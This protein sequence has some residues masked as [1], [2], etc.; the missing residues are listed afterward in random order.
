MTHLRHQRPGFAL[1]HKC[2][3]H[4]R[5]LEHDPEKWSVCG[6]DRAPPIELITLQGLRC[7]L[8]RTM[9]RRDLITTFVA[10]AA[11][12]VTTRAQQPAMPV[13]GF[14]GTASAGPFAH[15]V[16]TVASAAGCRKLALSRAE[17]SRSSIAGPMAGMTGCRRWRPISFAVKSLSSS[18]WA[19]K[20]RPPRPWRRQQRS[21]SY[22]TSAPIRSKWD[23]SPASPTRRQRD[24]GQL[25]HH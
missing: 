10:A 9:R 12:P 17:T 18:R 23:S 14:L 13:V 11:W 2:F 24:R 19:A 16:T 20:L 21:R 3:S 7:S 25:L 8:G 22:S 15:L 4:D 5:V 1:M 6:K